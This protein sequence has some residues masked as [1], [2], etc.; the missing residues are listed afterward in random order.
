[1]P[2][3]IITGAGSG[4]P[5]KIVTNKDLE[6]IV[7]TND[8]W[9]RSRTGI[10]ERRILSGDETII[11]LCV[12]ASNQALEDSGVKAEDIDLII[13]GTVSQAY[14]LPS[15]ACYIQ[16][17]IGAVNATAFDLGAACS[18]WIYGFITAS[19]FIKTGAYKNILVIGAD[20]LSPYTDW[21]DR[22][23][24]VIFAD[25][26]GA[27]VLSATD[28]DSGDALV[29]S[30]TDQPAG[31]S[32]ID[33][34]D[35][36]AYLVVSDSV[37]AGTYD[38]IVVTV[39]DGTDED[40]ETISISVLNDAPVLI[41]FRSQAVVKAT[42]GIASNIVVNASDINDDALIYI[43][44]GNPRFV[45][46]SDN[47]DGTATLKISAES[48]AGTYSNIVITV[49]DGKASESKTISIVVE[50]SS[51][52]DSNQSMSFVIYPQPVSN[53]SFTIQLN[54]V[55]V[56][57]NY[58]LTIFDLSGKSVLVKALQSDKELISIDDIEGGLYIVRVTNNRQQIMTK[59]MIVE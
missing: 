55:D 56:T 38:A 32:L 45:T 7:D 53:S 46:L 22:S 51:I 29:F 25:G 34:G 16:K 8:E 6:K 13:C 31:I 57:S 27:T 12:E 11:D 2:G 50:N 15:Q 49:S 48:T 17:E 42:V 36:T 37:K 28:D 24:C 19:Q 9:I 10:E 20:A 33:N 43:I 14:M 39:T 4:L 3:V 54:D 30:I 23:T 5:K 26:A 18:G 41:T 21:S 47:G 52:D 40:S 59:R 35:G 1:M 58:E 44:S